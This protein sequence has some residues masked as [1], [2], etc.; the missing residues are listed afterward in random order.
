MSMRH[1][2][3][4]GA[5]MAIACWSATAP[6]G[7]AERLTFER[8]I[9]PILKEYC[10]D[11]HGGNDAPK[12]KLDL[13]LKRFAERG[14]ES[15]PAIVAGK[16]DESYLLDR[17]HDAEM[18][19][20]EKKVPKDKIAAIE[21]WIAQGAA[22][23][24][25]EPERLAAGVDISPEERA[26]WAFQP[27]QRPAPPKFRNEDRMRTPIDAFVLKKL[28][29]HGFSF[30]PE[31]DRRTLIR[32]ASYDLTGLPPAQQQLDEFLADPAADAYERLVD[33]LLDSPQYGERWARHWL[34][35][36]GYA[37]SDGN[38]NDDTE[39]PYAYKYRDYVVR[40]F[41]ADMPLDRFLIEQIAGD[42]LVPRPWNNLTPEQARTLAA[43]GF[44]RMAADGTSTGGVDE[45][46]ASNQVVA[47]T[48]KIVGSTLLGLTVGCAQCHDHRYD[49]I[50][51]ADYY[52]LRAVFEPALDPSHWRRPV[53]RLVSLYH[54]SDRA[55]AK[56]I[57]A[58]AQ[59]LQAKVDEKTTKYVAAALD[60]ELGKFPEPLRS[61][62]RAA[63]QTRPRNVPPSRRCFSP[64]IPA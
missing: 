61:K 20:G 27:V 17:L 46:L 54:D 43:T 47:D 58:E 56:V 39:R 50:P 59:R 44:L 48:L 7:A 18:P 16:P 8:D 14:G 19:P 22:T 29:E 31:A 57:E 53:Q 5:V 37:D 12:G 3:H 10:L 28:R 51:Q 21:R 24:R 52:R 38:G 4:L 60:K 1:A 40:A 35:A 23:L 32:R 25:A 41:N 11:C 36:A 42:E 2:S 45:A 34:D 49:P 62:L 64:R 55:R 6:A 15:G 33:R 26:H 13:R 30:A 9:R 63:R